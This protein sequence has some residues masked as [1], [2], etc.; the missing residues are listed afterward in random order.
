VGNLLLLAAAHETGLLEALEHA[1]PVG[2]ALP[3]SR[4][5][6]STSASRRRLLL[7][8]LFL[9]AVGLRRTWNLR[10]YTGAGLA[11]LSGGQHAYS[12][13]HAERF[14]SEVT[15][16]GGAETLTAALA[17]WATRL[18]KPD[19]EPDEQTVPVYYLDGHRKPVVRRVTR[20]ESPVQPGWVG[21][22]AHGLTGLPGD[23][24]QRGQEHAGKCAQRGT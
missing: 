9:G 2:Q 18:W 20:H 11:L 8:L 23:E 3:S 21:K 12:Y 19:T 17:S 14:L 5:A 15:Q 1:V 10:A 4:L 7:T 16:A 22:E 24:S 13:R 6:R